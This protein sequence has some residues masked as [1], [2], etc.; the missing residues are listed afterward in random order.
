[1]HLLLDAAALVSE[2]YGEFGH[3]KCLFKV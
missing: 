1:V 3:A 2:F